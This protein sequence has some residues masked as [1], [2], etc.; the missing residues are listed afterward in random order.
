MKITVSTA[1]P[2]EVSTPLLILPLFSDALS[3]AP[4][5]L[6]DQLNGLVAAITGED[7]F[8]AKV[9]E[10]R[11]LYTPDAAA[12]RVLLLGMGTS[13]KI[14]TSILRRAA[15]KAVGAAS[16]L[17]KLEIAFALP[18]LGEMGVEAAALAVAEGLELGAHNFDDFKSGDKNPPVESATILVESDAESAQNGVALA[19]LTSAANLKCRALVNMPSNL[20]KPETLAQAARDIAAESD[21]KVEIW[22]EKKILE[23]KMGALYAVGMGSDSKPRFIVLEYVPAGTENDAP[24]ALVGKGMSFDSGGYSIKPSTGMEDMKDDMAGAGLV[25]SVMS[26][27]KNMGVKKR[28]MGLVATAENMISGDAMRPG[29]IVTARNGKTIEILNTDAEGRLIL[30]DAL[31]YA[32]EQKPALIVDFATLTGAIGIALGQEAAGLF[33]NDDQLSQQLTDAGETTGERL[34][35]LPI[36]EEFHGAMKGSVSD[37]KNISGDRYAGSIVAAT[38]LQEFVADGIPWAHLDIATVSLVKKEKFM[39][40]YGATGFG[41]RLIL[42]FLA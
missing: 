32:S 8:K 12:P 33:S 31:C 3:G 24:I 19:A 11:L 7:G 25:L 42:E 37:L 29:D 20:K 13:D 36:W 28:V 15:A 30:A 5:Q 22:D 9:G 14:S 39:T 16:A 6:N 23:E 38:F 2:L 4:A 35:R 40:K 27:L 18:A 26:A 17:H 21:L 41:V 10:S 1:A 34:W